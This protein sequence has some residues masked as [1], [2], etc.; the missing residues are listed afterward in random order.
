MKL[1]YL[2][3]ICLLLLFIAGCTKERVYE[4]IYEGLKRREQIVNP[5]SD[6]IHQKQQSYDEY[7][8]ERDE[9]LKKDREGSQSY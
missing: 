6:P 2:S 5:S 3:S 8:R 4:N 7:K 1:K 9:L